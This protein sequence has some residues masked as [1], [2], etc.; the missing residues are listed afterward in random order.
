MTSTQAQ[1]TEPNPGVYAALGALAGE[2]VHDTVAAIPRTEFRS[3]TTSQDRYMHWVWTQTIDVVEYLIPRLPRQ[4]ERAWPAYMDT[5]PGHRETDDE[6]L[7]KRVR[8]LGPWLVPFRLDRGLATVDLGLKIAGENVDKYLFRRD[9]IGG[10]VEQ[11]L[12]DDL[13]RST[14][15]DIGCNSGYFSLDLAARGAAHVDGVDLRTENV[16]RAQFVKEHY[17]IVNADFR[18]SD[19]DDLGVE[20]QWDVVLNLGLLYH[21]INPLDVL[22]RT[23]ELCRRFA[24][25][26]TV[27]HKEPVAAFLLFGDKDT[28]HPAEGRERWEFHPTYRGA[29]EA[30]RFAGFSEVIELVGIT[31]NPHPLYSTGNRRCFLAVK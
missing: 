13:P 12:G 21:V 14:V 30:I 18:V 8:E 1:S 25:I 19:A 15:L 16:A 28:D 27:C 7:A 2:L 11:L 6:E 20:Q 9:L 10:T 4:I 3:D 29:I 23:Y 17:G 5:T 26:D 22:R 24:I 31:D